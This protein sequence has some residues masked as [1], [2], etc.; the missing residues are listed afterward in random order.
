MTG[1]RLVGAFFWRR[2]D[3][4]GHDSCRLF[5]LTNGWLL[6]GMAVFAEA[7]SACHLSYSVVADKAFRTKRADVVGYIGNRAVDLRIRSAG[8][9][10]WR[11]AGSSAAPIAGCLDVDL[12][13]T[14]ATNLLPIRRLALRV[15]ERA[16][17]PAA[18][19]QF[20]RLRLTKLPQ[21]YERIARDKYAYESPKHGYAATLRVLPI[22]AVADYPRIFELVDPRLA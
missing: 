13:F 18:Y 22:G 17:A 2:L 16:D 21:R 10:R 8:A 12:G 19:V 5:A 1:E 15:G 3:Q 4:P 20:P 6:E 11:I 7:R 14:P 9:G